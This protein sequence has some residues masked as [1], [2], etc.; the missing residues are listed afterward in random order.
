MP[1]SKL[2]D[3][4]T[5]ELRRAPDAAIL[6]IEHA[7][8]LRADA[9]EFLNRH[10][11]SGRMSSSRFQALEQRGA[12][13]RNPLRLA[14]VGM[15]D[16]TQEVDKAGTTEARLLGKVGPTPERLGLRRQKHGQGPAT[17]FAHGL[18]RT[19]VDV[20]DIR[21]LLPVNLDV[22]EERVHHRCDLWILKAPW[23]MT[24]HQ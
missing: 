13:A 8:E 6:R 12:I 11:R 14:L 10:R 5:G 18:E 16:S 3:R 24:W 4:R 22:D 2:Q 21:P 7:G 15:G 17:P 9:L 23:A 1:R 20:V 19:R